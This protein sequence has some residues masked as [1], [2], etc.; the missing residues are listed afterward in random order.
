MKFLNGIKQTFIIDDTYNSSPR[1]SALALDTLVDFNAG[2]NTYKYA[3]LGDMLE[4]GASSI[5]AHEEVGHTVAKNKID[6]LIVV[7]ERSRDIARGAK[8]AG[9]KADDIF[10]FAT[11]EEAGRFIQERI[12]TG[13]IILVKGSQAVRMEKVVKVIMAEPLRA[14]E[15]L[16]RQGKEWVGKK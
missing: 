9:M 7:G 4:L 12:K 5:A 2:E 13:D 14:E 16:V 6:K 3:V 11:P 1:S 15:L 8:D 10:H